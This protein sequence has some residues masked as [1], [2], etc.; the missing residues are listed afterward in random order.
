MVWKEPPPV[1]AKR[2]AACLVK[3]LSVD[4]RRDRQSARGH[5]LEE[6]GVLRDNLRLWSRDEPVRSRVPSFVELRA[7]AKLLG[8]LLI[9]HECFDPRSAGR[10]ARGLRDTIAKWADSTVAVR[11][12]NEEK[13]R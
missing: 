13:H 3:T 8:S 4:V 1:L 11:A 2:A 12:T 5:A 6:I 7:Q 10:V 9:D